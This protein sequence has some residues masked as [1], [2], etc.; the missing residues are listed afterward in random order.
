MR[1]KEK[2]EGGCGET[3]Q[4]E[5][6]VCVLPEE[7]APQSFKL[8]ERVLPRTPAFSAA[9][10]AAA[11]TTAGRRAATAAVAAAVSVV[12]AVGFLAAVA[13]GAIIPRRQLVVQQRHERF[14]FRR[15]QPQPQEPAAPRHSVVALVSAFSAHARRFSAFVHRPATA[16]FSAPA[17][18]APRGSRLAPRLHEGKAG[19]LV[20]K[21]AKGFAR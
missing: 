7:D 11:A 4:A 9:F 13:A 3:Q 17:A 8:R 6:A 21:A 14:A 10:F 2:G 12:R 16:R 20:P 5:S 15:H 1:G 19:E 18:A